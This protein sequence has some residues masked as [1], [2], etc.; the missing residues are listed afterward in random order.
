MLSDVA[1]I[2]LTDYYLNWPSATFKSYKSASSQLS[3]HQSISF[4]AMHRKFIIFLIA[5]CVQAQKLPHDV[6]LINQGLPGL[7]GNAPQTFNGGFGPPQFGFNAPYR[8]FD[9]LPHVSFGAKNHF[10]G[11]KCVFTCQTFSTWQTYF[12]VT[13]SYS[14][15]PKRFLRVEIFFHVSKIIFTCQNIFLRAK[16]SL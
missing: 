4:F 15:T 3:H 7:K 1:H 11:S 2:L 5:S 12:Y 8:Q 6:E 9:I 10:Y 14:N 13:K 16:T